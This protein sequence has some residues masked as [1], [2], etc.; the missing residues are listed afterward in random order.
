M[1]KKEYLLVNNEDVILFDCFIDR[2]SDNK[3]NIYTLIRNILNSNKFLYLSDKEKILFLNNLKYNTDEIINNIK[4]PNLISVFSKN[5]INYFVFTNFIGNNFYPSLYE[6]FDKTLRLIREG[7]YRHSNYFKRTT[8][9]K[10]ELFNIRNSIYTVKESNSFSSEIG[11]FIG[12]ERNNLKTFLYEVVSS[13][14][15]VFGNPKSYITNLFKLGLIKF[16]VNKKYKKIFGKFFSKL[17]S[18]SVLDINK[19][20]NNEELYKILTDE[21]FNKIIPN[22]Y[23]LNF[24]DYFKDIEDLK[25]N[26]IED[27]V[28]SHRVEKTLLP[29]NND[30]F[31]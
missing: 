7:N 12:I 2:I 21:E 26:I 25:N 31:V 11:F 29:V 14:S 4:I 30:I 3:L 20:D 1:I 22:N 28:N 23:T 5:S 16:Y 18:N 17:I 9:S 19:D 15:S 24:N 27:F 6:S 13:S 8:I 10:N